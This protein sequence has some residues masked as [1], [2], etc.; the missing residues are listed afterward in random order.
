MFHRQRERV[1]SSRVVVVDR[2]VIVPYCCPTSTELGGSGSFREK[3]R[4]KTIKCN[5]NENLRIIQIGRYLGDQDFERLSIAHRYERK[6][7]MAF[8]IFSG[9]SEHY[10]CN[11]CYHVYK[12]IK[13]PS[14]VNNQPPPLVKI[15]NE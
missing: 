6:R 10:L 4:G 5:L 2:D 7:R 1:E 13:N 8:D 3:D 15:P 9:H 12:V 11:L 14:S